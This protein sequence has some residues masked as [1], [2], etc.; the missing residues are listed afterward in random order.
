MI[1]AL[2]DGAALN[3]SCRIHSRLMCAR[4]NITH[5]VISTRAPR[6]N[7]KRSIRERRKGRSARVRTRDKPQHGIRGN[8]PYPESPL[9]LLKF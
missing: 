9:K 8:S 5:A 7:L 6:R 1:A 4:I 2:H 3:N